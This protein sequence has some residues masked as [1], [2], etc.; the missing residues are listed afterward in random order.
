MSG[1]L[2]VVATPIGNLMDV[3]LRALE[4]LRGCDAILAEDT[5]HTKKLCARHGVS[6]RLIAFHAHTAKERVAQLADELAA[7]ASF[8]LVTDA[9]TPLVSDPGAE[10]VALAAE[11]GV[12]VVPVPGPSAVLGALSACGLRVSTF[13]FLGFLPRSGARRAALLASMRGSEDATVLFEAPNRVADTLADLAE[14]VGPARPAA[15]CREL[16]KLHE[17]IARGRLGEL[18][19]RFASGTRGEVTLVIEGASHEATEADPEAVRAAVREAI[20]RG[21]PTKALA[22]ALAARFG[23]PVREVYALAIEL[24]AREP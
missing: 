7:G 3:S 5:R 15:V 19:E 9:G 4:V 22:K 20:E 8:A 17:E 24:A 13:R 23:L 10:L 18:A 6:T 2:H 12:P 16:T 14:A 11:R 21:E 1:I